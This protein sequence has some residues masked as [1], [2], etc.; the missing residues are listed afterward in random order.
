MSS[1]SI[2]CAGVLVSGLVLSGMADAGVSGTAALTTDYVFRGV[3]QTNGDPA[4]QAGIEGVSD[5]GF[6]VGTWGSNISWLSD[7]S[8]AGA[9]ISSS[10][11]IDAYGGYR[12][13]LGEAATFDVGAI[14]Y[15]YP[16][17]FPSGFNSADTAEIYG[18]VTVG[19]FTAKYSYAITDLF[20]YAD[21]DG[22]GYLDL[23]ANWGFADSWTL[24][25]HA[26]QQWIEDNEA[27]EYI[28]WKV[29]VTKGFANGYSLAFA[30]LDTDTEE[31]LYT[32]PFGNYIGD[33]TATLTF[34]KAF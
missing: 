8:A 1:R 34:T 31:A 9:G 18:A 20:G 24:N 5:S 10:V 30:Y 4:L 2:A 23:A 27:Y 29:G 25:L 11:E 15:G 21:S 7:L 22:S 6:Y 32:N 28:D 13:T 33:A 3:S 26:G 17:D 16:G 12:G 19:I 14:Y